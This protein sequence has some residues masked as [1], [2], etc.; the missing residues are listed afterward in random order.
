MIACDREFGFRGKASELFVFNPLYNRIR[1][2]TKVSSRGV[3]AAKATRTNAALFLH[4]FLN[5][6][7]NKTDLILLVVKL[8]E[9]E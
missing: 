6:I 2:L 3:D 8:Y 4:F 1:V 5:N 9:K 7:E